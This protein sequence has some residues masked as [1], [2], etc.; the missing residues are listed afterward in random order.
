MVV[1]LS[2][3]LYPNSRTYPSPKYFKSLIDVASVADW[4]WSKFVY[5][6]LIQSVQKYKKKRTKTLGGCIYFSVQLART[7]PRILVWKG[8][9]V[10]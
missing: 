9:L 7:I 5:E 2:T 1:A 10:K 3:F 6:R 8:S 4:D